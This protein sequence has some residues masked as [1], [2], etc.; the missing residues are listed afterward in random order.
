[1]KGFFKYLFTKKLSFFLVNMFA[2]FISVSTI[3]I[4][5]GNL[6]GVNGNID[7]STLFIMTVN[8]LFLAIKTTLNVFSIIVKY[9][10][11]TTEEA[12]LSVRL[13][14]FKKVLEEEDFRL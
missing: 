5:K 6:I 2:M 9:K 1:M 11:Y 4:L 12:D 8:S 14:S 3:I 7:V 13:K 10:Y